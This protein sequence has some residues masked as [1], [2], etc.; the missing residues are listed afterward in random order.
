MVDSVRRVSGR[1]RGRG[2]PA[3]GM[4]VVARR[5]DAVN[6]RPE[7]KVLLMQLSER[8]SAKGTRYLSGFLGRAKLVAFLDQEP[9][10]FGNP[11]W[12]VYA[13][14]PV[15]WGDGAAGD[16]VAGAGDRAGVP[17]SEFLYTDNGR[18]PAREGR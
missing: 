17:R 1:W 18:A 4:V 6:G 15:P 16:R 5:G 2:T 14:E 9:D 7:A 8:T 13:S 3:R 12:S 11:R 10:K